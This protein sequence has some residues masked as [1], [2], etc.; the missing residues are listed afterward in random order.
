MS[1]R[2]EPSPSGFN[3]WSGWCVPSVCPLGSMAVKVLLSLSVHSVLHDLRWQV[4][5][6]PRNPP[7]PVLLCDGFGPSFLK[8][9]STTQTVSGIQRT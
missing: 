5:F 3:E 6:G 7:A 2:L 4:Q 9:V 8:S 1:L